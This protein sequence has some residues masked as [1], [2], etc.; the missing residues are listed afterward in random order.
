MFPAFYQLYLTLSCFFFILSVITDKSEVSHNYPRKLSKKIHPFIDKP[1]EATFNREISPLLDIK[2][3]YPKYII[4]IDP[5]NRS[6][7]GI[8]HFHILTFL[9]ETERL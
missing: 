5:I 9:L 1:N 8:K 3:N 7:Q 2:D 4:S 6:T